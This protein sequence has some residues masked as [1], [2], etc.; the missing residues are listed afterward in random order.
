MQNNFIYILTLFII[1]CQSLDRESSSVLSEVSDLKNE[2]NNID[3]LNSFQSTIFFDT[4]MTVNQIIKEI[5]DYSKTHTN[6]VST[7]PCEEYVL[8]AIMGFNNF[9]IK[10]DSILYKN[11]L[12]DLLVKT[13]ELN[14]EYLKKS[15][16][17]IS[18]YGCW[19]FTFQTVGEKYYI[20]K[21]VETIGK[22]SKIEYYFQRME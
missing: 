20:I 21:G 15:S 5:E 19:H 13:E 9:E 7:K 6:N 3:T 4:T 2:T 14:L 16:E 12:C 17:G 18:T 22:N 11:S 10:N 1:G 8:R